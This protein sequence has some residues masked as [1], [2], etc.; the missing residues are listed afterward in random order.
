MIMKKSMKNTVVTAA[1]TSALLLT[2]VNAFAFSDVPAEHWAANDI[3]KL[4][5]SGYIN[6]YEDGTFAP[7]NFITRA[8]F[9]TII[10]KVK[11]VSATTGK[12]FTDVSKDAW[13]ANEIDKAVTAGF[14]T[15]YDDGT[16][17]PDACISRA[18][19][20]VVCY[21]AWNLTPEGQLY[22][23]DSNSIGTWAQQ[24]VATLVARNIISGYEDGTFRPSDA[25][26]R[27]EV[28]KIVSRLIQMQDN[29]GQT[30]ITTTNNLS[31][32]A[33]LAKTQVVIKGGS[34]TGSNSSSSSSSGG[35]SSNSS[36]PSKTQKNA[37]EDI[38]DTDIDSSTLN[39]VVKY[40][41]NTVTVNKNFIDL[42]S[43]AIEEMIDALDSEYEDYDLSTK[44]DAKK[45]ANDV[46]AVVLAVNKAAS[47]VKS[48]AKKGELDK[49]NLLDLSEDMQEIIED[50]ATKANRDDINDAMVA[51]CENFYNQI[52]DLIPKLNG[53]TLSD[54][55]LMEIYDGTY[56]E[57]EKEYVAPSKAQ[58]N[59]LDKV[60]KID[61]DEKVSST[62]LTNIIKYADK[63][64]DYNASYTENVKVDS[65]MT[66][67]YSSALQELIKT[68]DSDVS[69]MNNKEKSDFAMDVASTVKVVNN[70]VDVFKDL[71][72]DGKLSKD[73]LIAA[74]DDVIAD[75]VKYASSSNSAG[76]ENAAVNFASELW[77]K[78]SDDI[79]ALNNQELTTEKILEIYNSK[80]SKS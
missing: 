5:N 23:A 6:G 13:Y 49:S 68:T 1:L 29:A 52:A 78:F 9:V 73:N 54:K 53:K 32:P 42:Y 55:D 36:A 15:G 48:L 63:N 20:A 28:A 74:K 67:L 64:D 47:Q 60:G 12:L 58:D 39:T 51:Y 10:N 45:F 61:K 80:M 71:A 21:K 72:K 35:S 25:I 14:I 41:N 16:V 18:E 4:T 11:G 38:M 50:K 79:D 31:T 75:V 7:G 59:S 56:E 40:S 70:A 37:L 44:T 27:A 76:V 3:A 77:V 30:Q 24:Q 69:D 22:F 17:R 8:E 33:G 46:S 62:D 26:T 66:D 19:V 65:Q 34:N 2:S 43:D 57:E